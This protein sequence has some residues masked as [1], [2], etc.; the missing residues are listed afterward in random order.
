MENVNTT[1]IN[2][3]H[4]PPIPTEIPTPIL[5]AKPKKSKNKRK[6]RSKDKINKGT[7]VIPLPVLSQ[8]P[9]S[10]SVIHPIQF[11]PRPPRISDKM[12]MDDSQSNI[13][14]QPAPTDNDI[15][16]RESLNENIYE[17]GNKRRGKKRKF[18]NSNESQ[19]DSPK[20]AKVDSQNRVPTISGHKRQTLSPNPSDGMSTNPSKERIGK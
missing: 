8:I 5:I 20:K 3:T 4:S 12:E 7:N 15:Q 19:K 1:N 17:F 2:P 11:Q 13:Q 14:T 10:Q 16:I 9:E 6:K 18:D